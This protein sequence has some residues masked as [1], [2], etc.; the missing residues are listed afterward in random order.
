MLSMTDIRTSPTAILW[1]LPLI[2]ALMLLPSALLAKDND[3]LQ[4]TLDT[5]SPQELFP[6]ADRIGTPEGEPLAAAVYNGSEQIGLLFLNSAVVNAMGYSGKPIHVLVGLDNQAVIQAVRM[7]KHHEPIVLVGIPE[8]KINA[9]IDGY[10]GLDLLDYIASAGKDQRFDAISGATVTVR[11]IDDSII[12]SAIKMA[13]QH[14]IA[15][16]TALVS[17]PR[18]EIDLSVDEVHSWADLLAEN[19][20]GRLQLSVAQINQGFIDDGD[21]AAIKRPESGPD[22][23]TFVQL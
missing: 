2:L 1:A 18:A 15:G 3:L 6:G 5:Y 4:S 16:L 23:A 10:V 9:L 21:E 11:V 12:R 7:V 13:R 14:S 22:D 17:G 8:S 19:A 20:V